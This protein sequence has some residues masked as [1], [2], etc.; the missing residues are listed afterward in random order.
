[1][2]KIQWSQIVAII[3]LISFMYY[4]LQT[5]ERT[6]ILFIPIAA[7][8]ILLWI[9]RQRERRKLRNRDTHKQSDE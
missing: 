2:T 3:I 8:N 4:S 7:I 9:L 1:M 6:L 5:G